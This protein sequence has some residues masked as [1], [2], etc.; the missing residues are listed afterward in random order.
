M[1]VEVLEQIWRAWTERAAGLGEDE[2]GRPTRLT[3][4]TVLDLV[5]HMAPDRQVVEFFGAPQVSDPVVTSGAEMLRRFNAPGGA[6]HVMADELADAARQAARVGPGPL[7]RNFAENTPAIL[8]VLCAAAPDSGLPHPSFGSVSIAAM[9]ETAVVEGTV[10]LLDL[11][12]AVGGPPVPADALRMTTNILADVHGP[13]TFIEAVTGRG[14][15][16]V[17]PVMR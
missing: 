12:D 17:L 15:A 4:W 3:G 5:A 9:T 11:I 2:W 8:D 10:H 16:D 13:A 6:A 1:D 14:G 7:V